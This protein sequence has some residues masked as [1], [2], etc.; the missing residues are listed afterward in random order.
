MAS[1]AGDLVHVSRGPNFP[2]DG[3]DNGDH[4]PHNPYAGPVLTATPRW[5]RGVAWSILGGSGPLDSGSNPDG[6]T[7][8]PVGNLYLP[9]RRKTLECLPKS[10]GALLKRLGR[11]WPWVA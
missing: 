3:T 1:L 8:N 6:P 7:Y 5:V 4:G 11:L 10:A 9:S 2:R